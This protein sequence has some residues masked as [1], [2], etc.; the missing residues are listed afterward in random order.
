[1]AE[2]YHRMG[3][4][5]ENQQVAAYSKIVKDYPLSSHAED[6]KAQLMAMKRPVPEVDPVQLARQKYEAENHTKRGLPKRAFS[7]FS[8]SPDLSQAAKAGE[9]PTAGLRPTIPVSVPA[10]AQP[11]LGT[12]DVTITQPGADSA[13][14]KGAEVRSP[15]AGGAAAPETA[16][17]AAGATPGATAPAGTTPGT[18]GAPTTPGANDLPPQNHTGSP[19][20]QLKAQQDAIRKQQRDMK[21]AQDQAKKVQA[22]KDAEMKAAAAAAKKSNRKKQDEEKQ[23]PQ[24]PPPAAPTGQGSVPPKQ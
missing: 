13:I 12:N 9:P 14:D 7:V 1:M 21:K 2:T 24:T 22:K 23:Q 20:Q 16:T 19:K 6:A 17:P 5:F 11:Q 10:T 3:D 4:K 8:G 15:A 18:P